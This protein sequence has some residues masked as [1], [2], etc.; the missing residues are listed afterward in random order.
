MD[1][2]IDLPP[3]F[4]PLDYFPQGVRASMTKDNKLIKHPAGTYFQHIPKDPITDLS[5]IPYKEAEELGYFK[6]DFLHLYLLENFQS[7]DQIRALAN[8]EPDW[9][10]LRDRDV[11]E[12]LFQIH[13]QF[14]IVYKV[15]PTSVQELADT[16]ALVRPG[17]RHLLNSY[18][19]DKK[20]VRPLIYKKEE[21]DKYTFKKGHAISYALTIVLE[22]HLVAGGIL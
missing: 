7:K 12:K 1:V 6:I 10:L 5:A 11:V 21:G 17:K 2:D 9:T 22:L 13:R 16:I 8:I 18:I 20:G 3:S 4:D 19:K 15:K 14:D